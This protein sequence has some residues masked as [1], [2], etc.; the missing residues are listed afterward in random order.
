MKLTVKNFAVAASSLFKCLWLL[1]IF[2]V[3]EER[4]PATGGLH[5]RCQSAAHCGRQQSGT[6]LQTARWDKMTAEPRWIFLSLIFNSL[7]VF[8]QVGG[9]WRRGSSALHREEELQSLSLIFYLW[10][11][12]AG[13][14]MAVTLFLLLLVLLHSPAHHR[15]YVELFWPDLSSWSL[16]TTWWDHCFLWWW[17]CTAAQ[18]GISTSRTINGWTRSSSFPADKPG[19]W[20]FSPLSSAAPH[21][22]K[23]WC[24]RCSITDCWTS[25]KTVSHVKLALESHHNLIVVVVIAITGLVWDFVKTWPS[26]MIYC[27]A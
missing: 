17:S 8:L 26:L 9:T 22:G 18:E 20:S 3:G 5:G 6:L 15:T 27:V 25:G 24:F 21:A 16:L 13:R 4:E 11:D 19:V 7:N 2:E 1:L 23:K 14:V 12:E 10:T